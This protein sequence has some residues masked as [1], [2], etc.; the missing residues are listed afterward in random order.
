MYLRRTALVTTVL[1]A[2]I[3]GFHQRAAV[4]AHKPLWPLDGC[5][6]AAASLGALALAAA[7]LGGVGG[8]GILL[9]IY[10]LVLDFNVKQ[11]VALANATI[12]G[13]AVANVMYAMARRHPYADRPSTNWTL[14]ILFEPLVIFGSVLGSFGN[15]LLPD[16]VL[17]TI[18]VVLYSSLSYTTT[19]KA[20]AQV[21]EEGGW[22]F[23]FKG[24]P[25]D[26][27]TA[28]NKEGE[29]V[30][31]L[32]SQQER[33]GLLGG[34]RPRG[35]SFRPVHNSTMASGYGAM[36]TPYDSGG[37][38]SSEE[39]KMPSPPMVVKRR[40]VQ[41]IK[42]RERSVR[43]WMP[44]LMT[45]CFA[46]MAALRIGQKAVPCGSPWYWAL[47]FGLLPWVL[48][49]FLVARRYVLRDFRR[50]RR[51][52]YPPAP[53]DVRW[54]RRNTFRWP[55]ICSAAGVMSGMLG[56]SGGMIKAPL[57]LEL[58]QPPT[59]VSST[60]AT[61]ILFTSASSTL[62]LTVFGLMPIDYGLLLLAFGFLITF[63][64]DW[65][66]GRLLGRRRKQSL[67]MLSIS[68]VI[69][70]STVTMALQAGVRIARDPGSA[71]EFGSLC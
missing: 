24:Q 52:G 19:R 67:A 69:T 30:K 35:Q 22:G 31:A 53:G 10:I 27:P 61:M 55:L 58:H 32:S 57:L 6:Y 37:Y 8:G 65:A 41:R 34:G 46:G 13:G 62:T 38:S 20:V 56:S 54:D 23:L 2:A 43:L 60:V 36:M 45:L 4:Y 26:E 66:A 42:A 29:E 1:A 9:P 51:F 63:V 18:L 47:T 5:D 12:L 48:P 70:I 44:A 16:A 68:T 40:V 21:H 25:P 71:V 3:G 28:A 39:A 59:V 17:Q 64:T 33:S 50:K 15:K 7:A 14:I 49:F 11:A